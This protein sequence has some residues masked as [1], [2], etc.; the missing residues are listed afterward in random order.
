MSASLTLARLEL[1]RGW[2]SLV[3]I[4]RLP[5]GPDKVLL[6]RSTLSLLE[7]AIDDSMKLGTTDGPVTAT[8]VGTAMLQ[9]VVVRIGHLVWHDSRDGGPLRRHCTVR[10]GRL[11]GRRSRRRDACLAHQAG[12]D[13]A[14]VEVGVMP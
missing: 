4:V 14:I 12:S 11:P 9:G 8:V 1:R 13:P 5:T 2:R 10:G 6:G 3:P 7:L